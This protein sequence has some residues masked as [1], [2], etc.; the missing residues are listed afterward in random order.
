MS[1]QIQRREFLMK[2]SCAGIAC[3]ALLMNAKASSFSNFLKMAEDEPIDPKNLNYC[4]YKC[5]SDC[6]FL[7]ASLNNDA[8]LKKEAYTLW[9]IE[10]KYHI[11]F[12]PDTIYC[13][14]CKNTEKPEGVVLTNCT[15]RACAKE[16]GLDC[17]VECNE[18]GGCTKELWNQFPDFKL[19][20]IE[21]QKKY[22]A[23][24]EGLNP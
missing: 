13:Y 7:V 16:K 21:M 19:Y 20:V 1:K 4:G 5:P 14:G 15:V 17:C 6:K 24:Q 9:K 22:Q 18:L 11:A 2:G 12:D 8:V 10:E 23:A 3:C